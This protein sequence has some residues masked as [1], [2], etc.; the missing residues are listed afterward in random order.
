M[1]FKTSS[2]HYTKLIGLVGL[3]NCLIFFNYAAFSRLADIGILLQFINLDNQNAHLWYVFGGHLMSLLGGVLLAVYGG[4]HHLN[5]I[6]FY[7]VMALGIITLLT[8]LTPSHALLGGLSPVLLVLTRLL[9]GFVVGILFPLIWVIISMNIPAKRLATACSITMAGG[10][11]G[12]L[13][14]I[15]FWNVLNNNF[16]HIE[17][18]KS[19]WR[20]MFVLIAVVSFILLPFIKQIKFS[21]KTVMPDNHL[22]HTDGE[23]SNLS[24]WQRLFC[25]EFLT[26]FFPALALST[27]VIGLLFFLPSLL[28][29]LIELNFDLLLIST[30]F[31]NAFTL[32]M[33][34]TGCI[35]FGFLADFVSVSRLFLLTGI[36]LLLQTALFIFHIQHDG[37]L[38]LLFLTMIGFTSGVIG[39]M[40]SML[41]RLFMPE[42][43]LRGT[44]IS[45]SLI[46]ALMGAFLSFI[47][48][49]MAY[50]LSYTPFW[51]LMV[52]ALLTIFVS[53][54]TQSIPTTDE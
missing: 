20:L 9:N 17:L 10:L 25:K 16:S 22:S 52:I 48:G 8:A 12:F 1:P 23:C 33:M 46:P 47:L 36:A 30:D 49:Y 3:V 26:N 38:I 13:M 4:R 32:I 5:K 28:L 37:S 18:L 39:V 34:M 27:I 11:F 50:Y 19:S 7:G 31:G 40:P 51:Y 6:F 41:V 15:I 29:P 21:Q 35:F 53:F 14:Q 54:Y 44:A 43:R 2:N 42:N 24:E 45:F